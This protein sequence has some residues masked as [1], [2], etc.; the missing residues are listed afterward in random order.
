MPAEGKR[1]SGLQRMWLAVFALAVAGLI[2]SGFLYQRMEAGHL[3][4]DIYNELVAIG[5]IKAENI[6]G[7]RTGL[8]NDTNRNAHSPFFR[9]AAEA[10]IHDQTNAALRSD[11]IERLG[12]E[13][14]LSGYSEALLLD[15]EGSVLLAAH[16]ME[17]RIDPATKNAI[18]PA[19]SGRQALLADLF[20]GTDGKVY[21]DALAPIYD[22]DGRTLAVLVLRSDAEA[23]L[24]PY[25]QSWP[26]PSPSAETLLVRKEGNEVVFLNEL[27]HRTNAALSLRFPLASESLPAAK[28]VLGREGIV[29]GNDYRGV[30]VLADVRPVQ[31]SPWF[32]VAKIDRSEFMEEVSYRGRV[33]ALFVTLLIVLLAVVFAYAYRHRQAIMYRDLHAA[34]RAK[35]KAQELLRATLL[36]IGDGVIATDET[37]TV[38]FLNPVAEALTGWSQS[39]AEGQPL[40]EVFHI[41]NAQT[42]DRCENP[43]ERVL[44]T[45]MIVGLANHTVLIARDGTERQIADSGAPIRDA[46]GNTLGVVLVFRDVTEAYR[47]QQALRES[48][49]RFRT[50]AEFTYDWEYWVSPDLRMIYSSPACERLTGYRPEE[51]YRDSQLLLAMAHEDDRDIVDRHFVEISAAETDARELEWRIVTKQGDVRWIAH[52]CRAV[53]GQDGTYLGRR[54]SNRDI[55]ERK[56]SEQDHERLEAQLRQAQKLEAVGQLAGGI[57]HDFNNLLQVIL[58]NIGFLQDTLGSDPAH[59]EILNDVRQAGTRA[60]ELTRQLLAFSRRQVIQ[61]AYLDLNALVQRVIS[62]IQRIIGEHIELRFMPGPGLGTVHVDEGQMQQVL[63]NLCVNARDAMP[64]G[65]TLVIRTENVELSDEYCHDHVWAVRG[66]YA[67]MHI[68]DTGHGMD[69]ATREQI[70]E[71]FFTTKGIGHGTGLGLAMVYGI[72]KHHGGLIHVYSEPERGTTFKI[73]IPTVDEPA[74]RIEPKPVAAPM[75]GAETLLFAE[76]EEPVRKSVARILEA[77]GYTV[78]QASDGEAAMRIFDEH[79]DTIALALLDVIMPKLGGREVMER[80][81]ERNPNMRFLFSSGYAEDAVHT[82]FILDHGVRLITKPYSRATLLQAV[83]EALDAQ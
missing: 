48:E 34:E 24:F 9:K 44:A 57:A 14:T 33:V 15:T 37:A 17:A 61:P 28:A 60:A 46:E 69:E 65:G 52:A 29:E 32:I 76:D 55:T 40:S 25:I 63:M 64:D 51:Y 41:V 77:A 22:S 39:A 12:L 81:K 6:A 5:R 62:M 74:Q 49:Q 36:G 68:T 35:Q 45:G 54:A 72:V 82:N 21:L 31:D 47:M 10:W 43:A 19:L 18:G 79:A 16:N 26:T 56:R 1:D 53:Y 70:F 50:V 4:S 58:V 75:G 20:L 8:L 71:P 66:R 3:R 11:F 30:P 73:Y 78:L 59:L 83:R 7:W 42:R 67:L 80:I 27:R 2:G 23:Y 13:V 38:S